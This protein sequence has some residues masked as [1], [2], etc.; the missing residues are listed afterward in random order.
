MGPLKEEAF[1]LIC[2]KAPPRLEVTLL[3]P[4]EFIV[5]WECA[6]AGATQNEVQG[7]WG[8]QSGALQGHMAGGRVW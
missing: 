4:G 2:P 7:Q 8:V 5:G 3:F 1:F 6:V